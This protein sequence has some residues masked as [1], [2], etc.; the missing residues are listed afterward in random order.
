MPPPVDALAELRATRE[1]CGG[2]TRVRRSIGP[3]EWVVEDTCPSMTK[4]AG[5]LAD[6]RAE[7]PAVNITI[8]VLQVSLVCKSRK[9]VFFSL[10]LPDV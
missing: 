1:D 6:G 10:E 5:E 4:G 3:C 9:N 2:H 8:V 7:L